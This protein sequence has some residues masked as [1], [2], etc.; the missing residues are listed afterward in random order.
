MKCLLFLFLIT[1]IIIPHSSA[2]VRQQDTDNF[3]YVPYVGWGS[4]SVDEWGDEGSS[5]SV[6]ITT[7][8]GDVYSGEIF[9]EGD[10]ETYYESGDGNEFYTVNAKTL[11]WGEEASFVEFTEYWDAYYYVKTSGDDADNGKT[12]GTAFETI[13]KGFSTVAQGQTLIISTGNY[14]HEHII[15]D[16]SGTAS[17]PVMIKTD[18]GSV[19]ID[20][21]DNTGIGIKADHFTS[22]REYVNIIGITIK[23]YSN[24]I[25]FYKNRYINF[26]NMVFESNVGTLYMVSCNDITFD[27]ATISG[28]QYMLYTSGTSSINITNS[29]FVTPTRMVTGT[30][31]N[32]YFFGNYFRSSTFVYEIQSGVAANFNNS[33]RGNYWT[34]YTGGDVGNDGIGDTPYTPDADMVDNFP[35]LKTISGYVTSGIDSNPIQGSLVGVDGTQLTDATDGQGYFELSF[36]IGT[37]T[38]SA[39]HG[40]NQNNTTL[41]DQW[42]DLNYNFT[43]PIVGNS[44]TTT[45][46]A[47]TI[48]PGLISQYGTAYISVIV[49]DDDGIDGVNVTVNGPNGETASYIMSI[50]G[51]D[52][53]N[54]RWQKSFVQTSMTGTY[55]NVMFEATDSLDNVASTA[56]VLSFYVQPAA[57]YGGGYDGGDGI[58]DGVDLPGEPG[59]DDVTDGIDNGADDGVINPPPSTDS[60]GGGGG[61][62]IVVGGGFWEWLYGPGTE[63]HFYVMEYFETLFIY[64]PFVDER[65]TAA[66]SLLGNREIVNCVGMYCVPD[67]SRASIYYTI[68]DDS[69]WF[70]MTYLDT[71]TLWDDKGNSTDVTVKIHSINAGA[72]LDLAVPVPLDSVFS[73]LVKIGDDDLMLGVRGWLVGAFIFLVA[74]AAMMDR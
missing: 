37:H 69:D 22:Y 3:N 9:T 43:L 49:Q 28:N 50:Q 21:V 74:L 11:F 63:T 23:N 8:W 32:N 16:N 2:T 27:M 54:S 40:G 62:S 51:I 60:D 39:S 29:V 5:I 4:I 52:N 25:Y 46:S 12:P 57:G 30:S 10:N 56:G 34:G 26:N 36:P 14:G 15:I 55:S 42:T 24:P 20:G 41:V 13:D 38:V 73:Y 47:E 18:G 66:F 33:E 59:Q 17:E 48:N 71:V 6:N 68:A 44:G 65:Q 7:P 45:F 70:F 64:W 35:Q 31:S 72:W 67:G 58:E 1:I 61:G 53:T 19:I